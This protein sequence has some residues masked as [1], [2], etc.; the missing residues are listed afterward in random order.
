MKTSYPKLKVLLFVFLFLSSINV[1][2]QTISIA[3]AADTR[4]AMTELI[5]EFN[6]T[7]ANVKVNVIYGSS[8]NLYQQIV[9]QAPFD[10]F[11]SADISYPKKLDSLKL[12]SGKPMLYAI[13]HLVLWSSTID[14]TKGI[15]VLKSS[16]IKKIAIANPKFAP[17]GKRAIE[18]L[19]FYKLNEIVKDKIVEGENVSQAAQFVLTGNAQVGL[20]ALSLALSPEMASKG[21]YL[22]I[23]EKSYSKLEQAYVV[24]KKS[25]ANKDVLKFTQFI[26]SAAAKKILT[27]Y[28]F[29]LPIK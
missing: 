15:D 3:A 18:C 28:G 16:D 19:K 29:S 24:M 11:F 7:N 23:D 2:S 22:L 5:K 20:I 9:N 1:F 26:E 14:V 4:F 6:K 13:G 12:V 27:K 21:K 8:G 17:Y 10:I 25:A